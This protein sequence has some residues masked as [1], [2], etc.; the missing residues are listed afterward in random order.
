MLEA[1]SWESRPTSSTRARR[2]S[3]TESGTLLNVSF[4]RQVY[5]STGRS[6]IAACCWSPWQIWWPPH[7]GWSSDVFRDRRTTGRERVGDA[8]Q[9]GEREDQGFLVRQF[10]RARVRGLTDTD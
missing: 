6:A 4:R 8:K 2:S 5:W 1:L 3:A 7:G 10:P 9:R